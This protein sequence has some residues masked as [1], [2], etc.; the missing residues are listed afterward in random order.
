MLKKLGWAI[1]TAIVALVFTLIYFS[2]CTYD[3][4]T[5]NV[6]F[7]EDVLPI[8]VSKCGNPGC[9]NSIDREK[10]LDLTN[11]DGIMKEVKAG[12]PFSS[13][14]YTE[15]ANGDMPPSS[16]AQLTQLE[17]T[18]IKNWIKSGAPNSSNCNTCDTTA[19]TFGATVKPMI[20]KWCVGCH[21]TNNAGGGH[22]LSSYSGIKQSISTGKFLGSINH[23]PGFSQMPKGASKLSDCELGAIRKWLDAGAPNN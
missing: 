17:K 22:D 23:T 8:F 21:T 7:Q 18:T 12:K 14:V 15:I 5:P 4:A 2:S 11:Y 1:S 16:H 9:H 10:K 3:V 6:C 19:F 13:E 20:D